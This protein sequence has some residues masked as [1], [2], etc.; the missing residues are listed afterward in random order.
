MDFG[1][2]LEK[3]V[4]RG[5]KRGEARDAAAR[6]KSLSVEDLRRLHNDHRLAISDHIEKCV[7]ALTN[8]FPGFEKETIYG[9]AGWGTAVKRD[10]AGQRAGSGRANFY[11]RLEMTVRPIS[12]AFVVE[13]TAKGTIRNKEVFNRKHYEKIAETDRETFRELIDVWVLD[14]AELFAASG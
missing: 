9:D 14:Y 13:I 5:Q 3:A 8:H 11:S 10:D 7:S 4:Q 12:S 1:E 2:R 6:A